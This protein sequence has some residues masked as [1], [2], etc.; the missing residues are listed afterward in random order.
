MSLDN[1]NE[2]DSPYKQ[3]CSLKE[4]EDIKNCFYINLKHRIDRREH[5]ENQLALLGINP[6]R[7]EAIHN[8][9]GAIGCS[10]SHLKLLQNAYNNKLDHILIVEDD[11]TFTKPDILKAQFSKFIENHKNNWDV[12]ILGGNNM[13]PYQ[14][15]DESCIKVTRC[16]TTTGYLVNGHYIKA[17]LQNVRM[18]LTRLMQNPL[19]HKQ[20]AI[21][22][23]WFILQKVSKWY[24]IIP[25]TVIQRVDYSDIEKK[26]TNYEKLMTD[27]SKKDLFQAIHEQKQKDKLLKQNM[28]NLSSF[29]SSTS[30]LLNKNLSFI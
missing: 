13:P 27:I 20:F 30:S 17:L 18:G 9:N 2:T 4:I 1:Y 19:E 6:Q 23:F 22:K 14:E 24:L 3:E 16:Q 25:A 21:D 28:P 29:S 26:I 8:T 12:I 15:I 7:F 5:V 10:M 11:I